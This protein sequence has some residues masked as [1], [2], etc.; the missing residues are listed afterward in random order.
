MDV[1]L[2]A[3]VKGLGKKVNLLKLQTD[4]RE[5]FFFPEILPLKLTLRL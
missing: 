2:N 1:I 4:M 3:D 5:I